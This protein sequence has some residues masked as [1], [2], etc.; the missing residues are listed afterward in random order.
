MLG[1]KIE[2]ELSRTRNFS[3]G[4]KASFTKIATV[5]IV[6]QLA[7]IS[8]DFNPIHFDENYAAQTK[9]GQ[10]IAHGL[11]CLGMISKVIGMELPGKG[12]IF[13]NERLD[14]KSPV[15][16]NDTITAEVKIISIDE[17]KH[18]IEVEIKCSNQ[19]NTVVLDGT[20]LLKLI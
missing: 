6:K 3:V 17:C 20:C 16:I 5:E 14:Y 7:Q 2:M 8:G 13:V 10:C 1:D 12:T 11:F 15:Y 18:L 4:Q 19:D 9:F